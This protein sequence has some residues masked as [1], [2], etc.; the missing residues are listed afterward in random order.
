MALNLRQIIVVA[1]FLGVC[2]AGEDDEGWNLYGHEGMTFNLRKLNE[3]I[4]FLSFPEENS[5]EKSERRIKSSVE[6]FILKNKKYLKKNLNF[7]FKI[8]KNCYPE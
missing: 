7:F 4:D 5:F 1:L 3:L 8:H 6:E 2:N